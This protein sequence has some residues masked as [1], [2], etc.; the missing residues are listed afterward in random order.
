ML[1]Y[2]NKVLLQDHL[3]LIS[4]CRSTTWWFF[5]NISLLSTSFVTL[6][7]ED[8]G[9]FSSSF[10]FFTIKVKC[11]GRS[12]KKKGMWEN[13]ETGS[14]LR[15]TFVVIIIIKKCCMSLMCLRNFMLL[16]HLLMLRNVKKNVTSAS[17][18]IGKINNLIFK[19]PHFPILFQYF[20][21]LF[22]FLYQ[23]VPDSLLF[24]L[25]FNLLF[26]THCL[27]FVSL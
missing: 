16:L 2:W 26:T 18:Q 17:F 27:L 23:R 19:S 24:T 15:G 3:T 20:Y 10:F 5:E 4:K 1:N 13:L 7:K 6:E 8:F 14:H 25:F 9:F 12:G 11:M 22:L 21:L